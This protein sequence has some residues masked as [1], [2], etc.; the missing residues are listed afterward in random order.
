MLSLSDGA[1]WGQIIKSG[2]MIGHATVR[3]GNYHFRQDGQ[4]RPHKDSAFWEQT[5]RWGGREQ[6]VNSLRESIS[7]RGNNKRGP[8][9]RRVPRVF[10]AI[11]GSQWDWNRMS[12]GERRRRESNEQ[13]R[14]L[15]VSMRTDFYSVKPEA[16]GECSAEEGCDRHPLKGS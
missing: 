12:Q 1:E 7:G 9:D 11:A 4:G 10:D 3:G 14:T 8:W 15:W 5:W 2:K 16:I 6:G 13:Y